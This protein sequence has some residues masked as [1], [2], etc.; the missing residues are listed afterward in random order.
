MAKQ[1]TQ[2]KPAPIWP[3]DRLWLPP[4]EISAIKAMAASHPAAFELL[5]IKVC[6]V[7]NISMTAGGLDGQRAT[8]FAEGRR[9]VGNTLRMIR[10]LVLAPTT[11]G[12]PPGENEPPATPSA[13]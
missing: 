2:S 9:W 1:L 3:W 8:D 13:S 12:P 6:R 5:L 11:R 10:D 4:H 7:D